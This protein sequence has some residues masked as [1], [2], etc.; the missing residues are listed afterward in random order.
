[1][2]AFCKRNQ[3]IKH[4]A[5]PT[6]FNKVSGIKRVFLALHNVDMSG[7]V[8][9]KSWMTAL[10]RRYQ[11]PI[12]VTFPLVDLM[13]FLE[14][15]PSSFMCEK[16]LAIVGVTGGVLYVVFCWSYYYMCGVL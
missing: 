14:D 10:G 2:L 8:L 16:A 4:W 15:A 1:M 3:E 9:T 7:Y 5:A 13:R 12:K 6:F 11:P